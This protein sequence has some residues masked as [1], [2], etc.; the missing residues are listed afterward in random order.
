[1]RI[2]SITAKNLETARQQIAQA[3]GYADVL[4]LRLDYWSELD[5]EQ[6]KHLRQE[7]TLPVMFTLRKKSQGGYCNLSELQRLDLIEQLGTLLPDYIDLEYD[8]SVEFA[9]SL[10]D[11]HPSIQLIRSYHDFTQTPD[12]L[13]ELLQELYHPVFSYFKIAV[14]AQDILDTLRLLCFMQRS[15]QQY[16]LIGIAMGEYGEAS[17]ILAP[18]VGSQFIYGSI[19]NE[20][21]AAPGQLTLAELT[22]LYRVHLLNRDTAI[23][24]LLGDPISSSRGPLLHNATFAKLQK[25][26]VYIR[27]R[28]PP[29][30]LVAAIK[31]LRQL[32]FHG[33]SITMPLKEIISPL[34]D[35]TDAA[36]EMIGAINTITVEEGEWIGFNTDGKGAIAAINQQINISHKTLVILGA[37]GSGKAIAYEAVR[38]GAK[39]II[40]NR[41]AEKAQQLAKLLECR[42][43]GFDQIDV[44]LANGYDLMMNTLP[45]AINSRI[46]D[47]PLKPQHFLPNAVVM[48]IVYNQGDTA[49]TQ[50]AK[51]AGCQIVD[52][53]EMFV[54]QAKLQ[55]QRWFS[56][57][58]GIQG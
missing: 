49:F 53:N 54:Q 39:I 14:Y 9:L 37:G 23:Y 25:N 51:A 2:A 11:K 24:A 55:Q 44:L 20:E 58:S 42:G 5:L 12:N 3:A 46:E 36:D 38:Q 52:G 57:P 56:I 19:N 7:I 28:V 27:L 47:F 45:P 31:Y 33:F 26:A 8:I 13:T 48:D 18:V 43:G 35:R 10:R 50:L 30:D 41:T 21:A 4:E 16:P 32:P 17:R 40:L 15:C 6:V 34:L 1:M 29:A 22:N